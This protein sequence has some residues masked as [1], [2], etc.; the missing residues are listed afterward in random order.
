M[1]YAGCSQVVPIIRAHS[2]QVFSQALLISTF[3]QIL[4]INKA[5]C[6][7]WPYAQDQVVGRF[8]FQIVPSMHVLASERVCIHA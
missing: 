5:C 2:N 4:T 7:V 6:T 3:V 1:E 8:C